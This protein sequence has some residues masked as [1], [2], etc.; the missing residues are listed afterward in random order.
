MKNEQRFG[1]ILGILCICFDKEISEPLLKV[2]W[3]IFKNYDQRL[4][5]KAFSKAMTE[6]VF[7][8]KPAEI[9]RFMR[10]DA[11]ALEYWGMLM[12]GLECGKEPN[13]SKTKEVVRRLGGWE[14]L[15]TLN[16][17]ELH[18]L[19]KRFVE[20]YQSLTEREFDGLPGKEY[21]KLE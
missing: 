4:V 14:R 9:I 5:E 21:K 20:H 6:C 7:F 2:Y 13:D 8:P 3:Q 16:Y 15:Q 10:E 12:T 19:E 18:W 1:E 11:N 17:D